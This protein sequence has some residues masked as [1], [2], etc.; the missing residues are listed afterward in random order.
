[1]KKRVISALIIAALIIPAFLIGSIPFKILC[2]LLA[3]LAFKEVVDLKVSHKSLPNVVIALGLISLLSIVYMN[4]DLSYALF[5]GISYAAIALVLLVYL[6]P[7]LFLK[8]YSTQDAFYLIGFTI[9]IGVVTN[10]IMMLYETNK[11]ILLYLI[12]LVCSVDI[13]AYLIGSLIGQKKISPLISPNKTLE[14]SLAGTLLSLVISSFYY[15]AII[16]N[17]NTLYIIVTTLSIIIMAQLGDLLF[18]KIKRE[19]NIKDFSNLIPGHGGILDRIDSLIFAI[20][21][22][23]LICTII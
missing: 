13:F 15:K 16:P 21:T 1:M 8:K 23:I 14:G 17:A 6:I 10:S 3:V 4:Y 19:N 18:S 5:L 22:Y 11:W 7:T 9:L 2:G 20:L 12:I